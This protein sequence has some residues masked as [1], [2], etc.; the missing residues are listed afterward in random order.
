MDRVHDQRALYRG[1]GAQARVAALELLH[2]EAVGHV[3]HARA[4]VAV[5]VRAEEAELGDLRNQLH[6]EGA[7]LAHVLLH[8]GQEL[9][10]HE[11]ANRV[12]SEPLLVAEELDETQ[13]VDAAEVGHECSG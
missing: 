6:G 5:E 11:L 9:P 2:H 12:P 13:E 4:A 7:V 8:E 3:A 1:E 10:R